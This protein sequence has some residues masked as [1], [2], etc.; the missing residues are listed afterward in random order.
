MEEGLNFYKHHLGDYAKDTVHLSWMEDAAYTRFLRVYYL[1]ER[2]LPVEIVECERLIRAVTRRE[3]EAVTRVL[4][5]F[6]ELREDGWHNKRADQEIQQYQA[7]ASTN[8]R[9]AHERTV[10]RTVARTVN[11]SST[12]RA[13]SQNHKPEPE[14]SK[15]KAMS[16][17]PDP[18]PLNGRD[19]KTES[20]EILDYLNRATGRGYRPVDSNLKPIMARL[21]SGLTATRVKEVV[22]HKCD[23]WKGDAKMDQYL[24]PDTLFNATKF[25]QYLGEINGMPTVRQ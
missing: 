13:P 10:A 9:I 16:G 20:R 24:R 1:R 21:K 2:P 11:E 8:R 3:K 14:E 4:H 17:K 6:F 22:L 25:E 19:Y 7:Q 23:Q 15:S 12:N 5:E 18:A